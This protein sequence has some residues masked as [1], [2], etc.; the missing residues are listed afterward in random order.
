M[1]GIAVLY[2]QDRTGRH[3]LYTLLLL[4]NAVCS[5]YCRLWFPHCWHN[6]QKCKNNKLVKY[7]YVA[8]TIY[9]KARHSELLLHLAAAAAAAAAAA[10]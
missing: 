4:C 8:L 1:C 2:S 9:S 10:G 5:T 7:S 3:C 6:Y